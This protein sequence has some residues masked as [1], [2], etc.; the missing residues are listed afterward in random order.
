M[1]WVGSIPVFWNGMVLFFCLVEGIERT[2]FLVWFEG[3][4][5]LE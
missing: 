5:G 1:G 2:L 3:Y 4:D